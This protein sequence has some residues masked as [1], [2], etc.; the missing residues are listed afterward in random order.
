MSIY[1]KPTYKRIVLITKTDQR[2][3]GDIYRINDTTTV[4]YPDYLRDE[5]RQDFDELR[6][7]LKKENILLG[8]IDRWWSEHVKSFNM[9]ER[10]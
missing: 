9:S 7:V 10:S 3:Y 8:D 5:T 1:T 6:N 2:I 4:L